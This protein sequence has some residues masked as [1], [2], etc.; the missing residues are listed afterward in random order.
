M[1]IEVDPI[2]FG[3]RVS[4]IVALYAELSTVVTG[5]SIALSFGIYA[6]VH[7]SGLDPVEALRYE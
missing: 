2:L 1:G 5:T 6:A 3:F 4:R 7:A